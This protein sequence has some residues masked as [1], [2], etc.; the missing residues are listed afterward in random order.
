M[1]PRVQFLEFG[2]MLWMEVHT[3]H[4][5][6]KALLQM[7]QQTCNGIAGMKDDLMDDWLIDK[8]VD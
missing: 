2:F 7:Y 3:C 5:C 1:Y 6:Q 4:N 8:F